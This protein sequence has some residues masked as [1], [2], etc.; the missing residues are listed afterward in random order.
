[1]VEMRYDERAQIKLPSRPGGFSQK[2]ARK[3]SSA[4]SRVG[5]RRAGRRRR[6]GLSVAKDEKKR[7][8]DSATTL[9]RRDRARPRAGGRGGAAQK[10]SRHR[11]DEARR[12]RWCGRAAASC[13]APRIARSGRCGCAGC[14]GGS[15]SGLGQRDGPSTA[16]ATRLAACARLRARREDEHTDGV[17]GV[18]R[19]LDHHV[20]VARERAHAGRDDADAPKGAVRGG[21]RR[22][23]GSAPARRRG[24]RR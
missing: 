4:P 6:W 21:G 10:W 7:G 13:S 5:R 24:C 17:D 11:H 18:G 9:A 23:G 15:P 22:R 3:G 14:S 12:S 1:M 20:G 8:A 2:H 19:Q 16:E